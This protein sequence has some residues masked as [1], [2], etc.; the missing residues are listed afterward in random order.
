MRAFL[1]VVVAVVMNKMRA[2]MAEMQGVVD[3][4]VACGHSRYSAYLVRHENHGATAFERLNDF[5][6]PALKFLSR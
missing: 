3:D 2:G 4:D 6:Y 1:L 5:I